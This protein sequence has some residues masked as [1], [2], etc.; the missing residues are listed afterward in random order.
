M[1]KSKYLTA[2]GVTAKTKTYAEA[3]R[4]QDARFAACDHATCMPTFDENAAEDLSAEEVRKRW[5]RFQ[6]EC[7]KCGSKVIAYAS[8]L[9]YIL[10]DW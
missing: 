10:G 6:G 3:R 8:Y 1:I 2:A 4:E 9:H 5:P 7:S